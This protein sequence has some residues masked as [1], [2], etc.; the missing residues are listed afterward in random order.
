MLTSLFRIWMQVV[1][2]ISSRYRWHITMDKSHLVRCILLSSESGGLQG[3]LIVVL[4]YGQYSLEKHPIPS[5]KPNT[6][7]H[8]NAKCC[9]DHE[10]LHKSSSS[11]T[12]ISCVGWT[13]SL[14]RNLC[15]IICSRKRSVNCSYSF[16][17]SQRKPQEIF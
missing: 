10:H 1:K 4:C 15:N 14:S 6:L 17:R 12:P 13:I 2:F 8:G 16:P 9:H 5:V 11:E 3:E 7:L